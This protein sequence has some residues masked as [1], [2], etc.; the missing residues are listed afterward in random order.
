MSG[1]RDV[2]SRGSFRSVAGNG[3]APPFRF[4]RARRLSYG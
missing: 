3:P 2:F 4:D 1:P